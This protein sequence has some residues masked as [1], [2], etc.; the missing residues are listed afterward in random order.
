M[1]AELKEGK[2]QIAEKNKDIQRKINEKET[3]QAEITKCEIKIKELNHELKKLQDECKHLKLRQTDLEKRV[4]GANLKEAEQLSD[5]EGQQLEK[6]IRKA[7]EMKN[8]LGRTVNDKA[9]THFEQHEKEYTEVKK[10]QKIV[11][12]DKQKL[13]Q[14]IQDLDK[15]KGEILAKAFEQISKDFGSIFKTLLP[16]AD[17]KLVPP[18]GQTILQGLE[19]ITN[20]F[21]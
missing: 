18:R 3:H 12:Q 10:K 9:Q 2:A 1:Q 13:L 14:V 21:L 16:G 4:K 19:V 7:Q 8:S 17:A 20:F 6:K 11:E 15:K 5:E